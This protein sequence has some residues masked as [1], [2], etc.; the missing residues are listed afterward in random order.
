[1][2]EVGRDVWSNLVQFGPRPMSRWLWEISRE[3]FHNLCGSHSKKFFPDLQT[4][5]L[6]PTASGP[7]PGRCWAETGSILCAP[8]LQG[9]IGIDE[10]PLSL[11]QSEQS[12]L[13][14]P[15]LIIGTLQ[16]LH[17][18]CG[19]SLDFVQYA[20]VILVVESPEM[21]TGLQMWFSS[22]HQCWIKGKDQ[23]PWYVGNTLLDAAH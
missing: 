19:P 18:L 23:L 13:S 2:A 22:T 21:D 15:F 3:R 20:H 9:F 6:V 17:H 4:E 8:C 14:Q 16:S 10:I 11:L 5:P 7:G 12:Q 1:M